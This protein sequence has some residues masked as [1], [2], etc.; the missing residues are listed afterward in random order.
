M[1]IKVGIS[2][3]SD[4]VQ[5]VHDQKL[6]LSVFVQEKLREEAKLRNYQPKIKKD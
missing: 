3:P 6:K 5:F 4:L 2:L 1:S